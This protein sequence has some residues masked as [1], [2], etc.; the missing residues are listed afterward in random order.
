M[1]L[2]ERMARLEEKVDGID[3]KLDELILRIDKKFDAQEEQFAAKWVE[4]LIWIM[5]T[6]VVGSLIYLITGIHIHT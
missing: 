4:R 3:S 5:V 6:G 1:T 2:P